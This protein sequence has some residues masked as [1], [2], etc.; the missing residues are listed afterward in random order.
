MSLQVDNVTGH[1]LGV[2]TLGEYTA[3][4]VH[5]ETE[6][7]RNRLTGGTRLGNTLPLASIKDYLK[8]ERGETVM[9]EQPRPVRP[10]P[11]QRTDNRTLSQYL[12]TTPEH[13]SPR[14][15]I[16]EYLRQVGPG[17]VSN[18]F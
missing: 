12:N 17:T 15:T 16:V 18:G 10:G 11:V 4:A 7:Y 8:M 1:I 3:I 6:R 13:G 5:E 14:I 2:N 9:A